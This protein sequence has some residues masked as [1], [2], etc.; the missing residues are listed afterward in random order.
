VET[1]GDAG[2]SEISAVPVLI[3][4]LCSQLPSNILLQKQFMSDW[5]CYMQAYKFNRFHLEFCSM[6]NQYNIQGF[7]I[8]HSSISNWF[9]PNLVV[10]FLIFYPCAHHFALSS[11][12]HMYILS[13]LFPG[14]DI[15]PLHWN[16]LADRI[17]LIGSFW[18]RL[19]KFK[20]AQVVR[21]TFR[22]FLCV[23]L[24]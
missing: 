15:D 7:C 17:G 4:S 18:Q 19:I 2:C 23:L 16:R 13:H 8:R 12:L 6:T 3:I 1:S 14:E 20:K 10:S 9:F 22:A 5:H 11:F 24:L 21:Y